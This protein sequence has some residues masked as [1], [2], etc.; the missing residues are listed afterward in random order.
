[1]V[2]VGFGS[3]LVRKIVEDFNVNLIEKEA[4]LL[5]ICIIFM[6]KMEH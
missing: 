2:G 3:I 1:M 4:M 5:G 6:M